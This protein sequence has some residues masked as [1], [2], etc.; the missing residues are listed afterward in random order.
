MGDMADYYTEQG[1]LAYI[2][3][4]NGQCEDNCQYCEAEVIEEKKSKRRKR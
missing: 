2:L 4:L 3:H 1:E